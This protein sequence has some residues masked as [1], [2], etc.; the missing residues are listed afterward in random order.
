M[1][2]VP[3]VPSCGLRNYSTR[4]GNEH[5]DYPS[6]QFLLPLAFP[7]LLDEKTELCQSCIY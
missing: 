7:E 2:C 6:V 4:K 3:V 1:F 5:S